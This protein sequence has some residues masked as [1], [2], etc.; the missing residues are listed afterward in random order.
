MNRRTFT[1]LTTQALAATAWGAD[2][3]PSPFL[4]TNSYPWGTF[5][6]RDGK[7][8]GAHGAELLAAIQ[9]AGIDGY[10]G[11]FDQTAE[12]DGLDARLKSHQLATRSLYINSTLHEPESARRNIDRVLAIAK[13]GAAAG[14]K[15]VVTNPSPIRW[16]GP[17]NKTD[18]QLESQAKALDILG[19]ELR[20]LGL[21]LAYHNHDAELRLGGREFHHMLAATDPAN[22]KFCLDAHWIYRGCGDSQ[23]AVFDALELYGER[24]VE[25]H[26]RQ[27]QGGVWSEAFT[28]AGD[29]DYVRIASWLESRK[30]RPHLCLKQA[31]EA[32][33]PKTMDAVAAHK[34]SAA[35]AR[36]TF[37]AFL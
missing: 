35:N 5:A 9:S 27:S 13:L 2:R 19:A 12:F 16:G 33:S 6:K 26:L 34:L 10:E 7:P 25:L 31:V 30:I 22:V 21:Q 11:I 24:V 15:I 20:E 1:L 18:A 32:K 36:L 28:G 23:V 3:R 17:E 37:A 8:D 29:I 4:S 14:A